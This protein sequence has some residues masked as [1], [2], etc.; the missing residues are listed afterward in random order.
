MAYKRKGWKG[1]TKVE[2]EGE[3]EVLLV[4][5]EM[6]IG[7]IYGDS[8]AKRGKYRE[9]LEELEGSMRGRDGC[10]VGDWNAHHKEWATV[11]DAVEVCGRGKEL[12]EWTGEGGWTM[13]PL[14][15]PTWERERK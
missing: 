15:H 4:V 12:W 14:G 10:L 11:G 1:N 2:R 13:E 8:S 7:G 6:I 3:R 5:G 9:W